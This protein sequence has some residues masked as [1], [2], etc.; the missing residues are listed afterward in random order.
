MF[1]SLPI[2]PVRTC[3]VSTLERSSHLQNNKYDR[4]IEPPPP[5]PNVSYPLEGHHILT[6]PGTV[7]ELAAESLF[8]QD[9]DA[10]TLATMLLDALLKV[11]GKFW[12]ERENCIDIQ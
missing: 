4:S 9:Q 5:P 6:V 12:R 7:R 11:C 10:L 8:E 3:F 2:Y 1:S